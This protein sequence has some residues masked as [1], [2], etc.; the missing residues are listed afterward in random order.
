[1]KILKPKRFTQ[2]GNLISVW[3]DK[4]NFLVQYRLLKFYVRHG[5]IVHKIQNLI[6]LHKNPG[7]KNT[8]ISIL[9]KVQQKLNLR[10]SYLKN[11]VVLF[12]FHWKDDGGKE[13]K[14]WI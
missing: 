8:K 5:M 2:F 7:W 13:R 12:F 1:M 3:S 11:M 10:K 4:K 9:K 14:N 6:S